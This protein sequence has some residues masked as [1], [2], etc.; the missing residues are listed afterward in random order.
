M[1]NPFRDIDWNSTKD[2]FSEQGIWF[3]VTI[4]AAAI[5]L[6]VKVMNSMQKKEEAAPKAPA[7]DIVL[8]REIRDGLKK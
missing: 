5:F 8:L 4:V 1:K 3:L 7:E 2:W 6:A